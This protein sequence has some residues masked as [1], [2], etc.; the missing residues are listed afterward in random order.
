MN[1]IFVA[2]NPCENVICKNYAMC[3]V[4]AKGS[5]SCRCPVSCPIDTVVVCGSNG[6]EYN[7]VCKLKQEACALK[8]NI[9]VANEGPCR[10]C[11]LENLCCCCQRWL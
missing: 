7:G 11:T 4:D 10:K 1:Y 8:I 9:T 2:K 3:Q 5:A 6:K